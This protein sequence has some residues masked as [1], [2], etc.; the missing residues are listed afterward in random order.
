MGK[1]RITI[2]D[3]AM[4]L[5]FIATYASRALNG[6]LSIKHETVTLVR[7]KAAELN[8]KHNSFA[9]NLLRSSSKTI[10][11]IVPHIN[12]SFF[13]DSIAGIEEVCF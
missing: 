9:A 10:G 5:G 3:I 8:Y 1:K 2:Y 12:Q 6:Y 7:N 11:V 13:S 4:E